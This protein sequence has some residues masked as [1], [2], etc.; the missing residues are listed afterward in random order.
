[1]CD[2]GPKNRWSGKACEQEKHMNVPESVQ[3]VSGENIETWRQI[4]SRALFRVL[5][6]MGGIAVVAASFT[7]ISDGRAERISI[8]VGMYV[9][10]LI[11]AFLP[12]IP[13]QVQIGTFMVLSL[14]FATFNLIQYGLNAESVLF[15]LT[16][17]FIAALFLGKRGGYVSIVIVLVA[18][19]V[20][21]YLFVTGRVVVLLSSLVRS[22]D[23]G[24]WV[25]TG[26]VF[27][28]L[29]L[30]VVLCL[31]YM[32]DRLQAALTRSQTLAVELES[33]RAQLETRV[34]ERTAQLARQSAQ[35]ETAAQVA[36]EAA[37]IQ[38]VDLLLENTARLVADRFSFYNVG[39][40]MKD[41]TGRSLVLRAASSAGGQHL[42]ARGYRLQLSQRSIVTRVA[43]RGSS[44]ISLDVG[45]DADYLAD[46][47]LPETRSEI[48]LPLRIHGV[49]IGVVDVQSVQPGAFDQQDAAV[50]QTLAD[51]IAV[52]ISNTRLYQQAQESVE[53]M[54]RAYGEVSQQA[55]IQLLRV[56]SD[57]KAR[58]DPNDELTNEIEWRSQVQ[59]ALQDERTEQEGKALVVPIRIRDQVVGFLD[60]HKPVDDQTWTPEQTALMETLTE[61][62]G[63]ALENARLYQDTRQRAAREQLAGAVTARM[64]ESLDME[65]VLRTAAQELRQ[66]LGV[67]E[68]NIRLATPE[69]EVSS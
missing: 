20:V 26:V 44:H 22:A 54:R 58:Y 50:L 36:R 63:V 30:T 31:N 45:V 56:T 62:L 25:T 8:Y 46:A 51:Q 68:L 65:I 2:W 61:Q 19:A 28:M 42:L 66:A 11:V 33:E 7:A 16:A 27:L 37:D 64:R 17:T 4:L 38:D 23:L 67:S 41:E 52:A 69:E 34:A 3:V 14:T 60:A 39:I 12:K 59:R 43:N 9:V 32:F 47:E 29:S 13:Y 6:V 15:F 40:F 53:A 21:M 1:M 49:T 5:I 48:A 55:W 35:L 10:L 24:G 18:L 57:L